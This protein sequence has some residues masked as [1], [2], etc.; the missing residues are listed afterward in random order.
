MIG[1]IAKREERVLSS[2]GSVPKIS[3]IQDDDVINPFDLLLMVIM[4]LLIGR[5]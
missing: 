5:Q 4:W 1:R 3:K 2:E